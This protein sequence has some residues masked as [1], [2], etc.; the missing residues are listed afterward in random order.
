MQ[1]HVTVARSK[2]EWIFSHSQNQPIYGTG[3][4]SGNNP[5]TWT[6]ISSVLLSLFNQGACGARYQAK[7][8]IHASTLCTVVLPWGKYKYLRKM[9]LCNN[10]DIFQEIMSEL[11]FGLEFARAYLNDLLVVS[12]DTFESH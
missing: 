7:A 8:K 3:Q 12:K 10:P 5:H 4:G 2:R 1:Y 11:M 6:M 9:G